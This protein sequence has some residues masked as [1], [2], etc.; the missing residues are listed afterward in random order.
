MNK[1]EDDSALIIQLIRYDILN[2]IAESY[3]FLEMS[4]LQ[5]TRLLDKNTLINS[6]EIYSYNTCREVGM[7]PNAYRRMRR[8]SRD[9]EGTTL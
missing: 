4:T 6:I 2:A 1:P 8:I 9:L 3:Y 7:T 5:V